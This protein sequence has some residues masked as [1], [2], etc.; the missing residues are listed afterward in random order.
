[1]QSSLWNDNTIIAGLRWSSRWITEWEKV[2]IMLFLCQMGSDSLLRSTWKVIYFAMHWIN[3]NQAD[4][5]VHLFP[6]G[7]DYDV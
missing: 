6:D 5:T 3:D 2:V 1:M 7:D 4:D